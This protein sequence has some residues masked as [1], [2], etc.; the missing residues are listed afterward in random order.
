MPQ[1]LARRS[2]L[3]LLVAAAAP[4]TLH[5]PNMSKQGTRPIVDAVDH[6]IVGVSDLDRGIAHVEQLTGVQAVIGGVHPGRGTRNALMALGG[7]RYLEIMGPDPAQPA[8]N[9]RMD[10][11]GLDEPRLIG[12]AAATDD[13]RALAASLKSRGLTAL[14]PRDGSRARPD[15]RTLRWTTLMPQA[16]F[17]QGEIDPVPFFIE[18]AADSVHP[19]QETPRGCTLT[20][21]EFEHP[22]AEELQAVFAQVGLDVR[23]RKAPAPTLVARLTAPKGAVVLR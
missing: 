13:I 18:W 16:A 2:F 17:A 20:A 15:G 11:S 9:R 8:T 4:W 12:W 21:L 19:S 7:R 23:V 1:V 14:G 6:L 5:M 3:E 22:D 10:F